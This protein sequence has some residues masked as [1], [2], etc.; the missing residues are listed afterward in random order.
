MYRT[1]LF[2]VDDDEALP[3]AIPMVAAYALQN[4]ARV[5]VLHVQ[6]DGAEGP[7]P[8]RRRLVTAVV[9]QLW[10]S[11]VDACGEL[12]IVRPGDDVAEVVARAARTADADLVAIAAR[13]SVGLGAAFLASVAQRVAAGLE[14]PVLV[15]RSAED[16]FGGAGRVLVAVDGTATG[17]L[18]LAEAAEVALA[19][20]SAV[21]VVHV[22]PDV[23]AGRGQ[24]AVV[25]RAVAFLRRREVD[26]SGEL[27]AANEGVAAAI[28]TS[29]RSFGA[30]VLVLGSRRPPSLG[31]LLL[32][33]VAHQVV[34]LARRPVLL[35]RSTPGARRRADQW[36]AAP[37]D[38]R[39]P[40]LVLLPRV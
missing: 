26:A 10:G 27:L 28:V 39:T 37:V 35:A 25:D 15:L 23:T 11:G 36:E 21:R 6:R 22:A 14:V 9:E 24:E 2:A 34:R 32:G 29:A 1:I 20:G 18:A 16:G 12:R 40:A 33:S 38:S 4:R 19:F 30:D 8:V 13:G 31:G 17:G 5:C 7:N 3:P